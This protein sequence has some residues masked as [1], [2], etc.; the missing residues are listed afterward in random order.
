MNDRVTIE[1]QE[2][3]AHVQLNRPDKLNALDVEM[4]EALNDAP[5]R[6]G[7]LGDVRAVVL[8]GAGPSFCSG[9]DVASCMSSPAFMQRAFDNIEGTPAN[10]VQHVAVAWRYL[11]VP[12]IA[13]VTG[14]CY[15]G[16]LQIALGADLRFVA[17]DA[18]LS[19]MEIKWGIVPDMGITQ[20]LRNLV[21]IDQ[22]KE[23]AMSG[24]LVDGEEACALGLATRV[25]DDP[26]ADA[27]AYAATLAGRSPDA[28]RGVK[29]LFNE[30]WQGDGDAG[31]AL[32]AAIQKT[33]LGQPAQLES[34]RAVFEKRQPRF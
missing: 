19:V 10:F 9:L 28:I 7:E 27:L 6:I 14:R 34:A 22:A 25:C 5:Q 12:V 8:S 15:G 33:L 16:G 1:L 2:H 24:R 26:V 4:F 21:R 11:T 29:R 31:L 32:E 30:A 23:L 17:A 18:Q 3:V 20:T 13:A